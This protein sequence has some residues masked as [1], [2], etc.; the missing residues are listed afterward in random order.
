MKHLTAVALSGGIDSLVAAGLLQKQNHRIIGLH[1][2]TGYETDTD[3]TRA[4]VPLPAGTIESFEYFKTSALKKLA[5]IADR[6]DIKIDIVDCR[7]QFQSTVVDYFIT[8]YRNGKTPNPCLFCNPNIKFGMLLEAAM[9]RGASRLATGH[10]ALIKKDSMGRFHLYKGVDPL[11]EQSY[12]LAMLSQ[13]QLARACFPL[14]G[15]LKTDVVKL[16][17][18]NKLLPADKDESQDICFI[19]SKKYGAFLD[20]RPE[21][22]P[23]PGLI[24]DTMGTV[25]GR[26][27]G[28]HLFTIGQR[29]GINCPSAEPYYVVRLDRQRN[30]LIVGRKKETLAKECYV[31]NINWIDNRPKKPVEIQVRL[32]YRHKA[33]SAMLYR[34]TDNCAEIR[35][36]D[37]QE[38]VTPGQGAVF[39][40]ND[41]VLGGGWIK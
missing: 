3:C 11:K 23:R 41:E 9:E 10:Y 6:L 35:F 25:L 12:F 5:P 7:K 15:M 40:K 16:A 8:T 22:K 39:Y 4:G 34:M 37:L 2:I 18:K 13:E 33:V 1:F 29:R 14:G 38:A 17:R 32:R 26:H 31:E 19:K 24:E 20:N 27:K 36:A 21:F 30:R 28:L